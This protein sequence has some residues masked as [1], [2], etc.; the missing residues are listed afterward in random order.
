MHQYS[1]FSCKP[2]VHHW[3][4]VWVRGSRV[5]VCVLRYSTRCVC[6]YVSCGVQMW[7][8]EECFRGLHNEA[9]VNFRGMASLPAAQQACSLL[10]S[11]STKTWMLVNALIN[12]NAYIYTL[13]ARTHTRARYQKLTSSRRDRVSLSVYLVWVCLAFNPKAAATRGRCGAAPFLQ[14]YLIINRLA[15]V[16]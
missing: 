3:P 14:I 1:T 11:R 4:A 13:F 6:V 16:V 5:C 12:T 2:Q 10:Q 8:K 15:S 7:R 9:S